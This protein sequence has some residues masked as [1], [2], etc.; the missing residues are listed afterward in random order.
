MCSSQ[1][2]NICF[3][4]HISLTCE[5]EAKLTGT[6]CPR[7]RTEHSSFSSFLS[8]ARNI[9]H[10]LVVGTIIVAHSPSVPIQIFLSRAISELASVSLV[11]HV[12]DTIASPGAKQLGNRQAPGAGE[13]KYYFSRAM[14]DEQPLVILNY[15]LS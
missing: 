15:S 13:F 9:Q 14:Q 10:P 2:P 11:S 4:V 1:F 3:R 12:R 7:R 8:R 6:R 5:N